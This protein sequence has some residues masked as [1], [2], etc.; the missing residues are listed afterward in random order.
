MT[1]AQASYLETL[2]QEAGEEFDQS[3]SKA[4]A[5]QIFAKHPGIGRRDSSR[6]N[7][8]HEALPWRLAKLNPQQFGKLLSSKV[9]GRGGVGIACR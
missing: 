6:G 7:G 9:T 2:C 1:G 3:L 4:A 5:R 8:G